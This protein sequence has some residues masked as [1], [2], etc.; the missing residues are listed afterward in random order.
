MI[1]TSNPVSVKFDK[2]V[3]LHS[4]NS[5]NKDGKNAPRHKSI[6][7]YKNRRNTLSM[8]PISIEQI[9]NV[10][11]VEEE[12]DGRHSSSIR[13]YKSGYGFQ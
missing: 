5:I 3:V 6:V 11:K 1:Q 13:I 7:S 8:I 4:G 10:G 12:T 9:E 2:S